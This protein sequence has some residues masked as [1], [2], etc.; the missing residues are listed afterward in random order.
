VQSD[1]EEERWRQYGQKFFLQLLDGLVHRSH[2]D[3][4]PA[5]LNALTQDGRFSADARRMPAAQ[6]E[7]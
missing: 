1:K 6:I 3:V 7:R 5:A 2:S 4:S